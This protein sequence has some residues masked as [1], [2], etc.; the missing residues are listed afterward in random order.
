MLFAHWDSRP[1]SDR[2][3]DP[4]NYHTPIDGANDGAGAC[5]TLLEI[6]RQIGQQQPAVGI[7]ILFFDAEDW[8]VP[9]FDEKNQHISSWC[10]GSDFWARNPHKQNYTARY[11]ILLDMVSAPNARF[12]KEGYSLQS[13]PD[14]VRKVWEAAQ[15]LGYGSYFVAANGSTIEDDH[16]H[17]IRH[18]RI[19][20]IDIIQYDPETESGFGAYW[21]TQDDDMDHVSKKRLQATGQTVMYVIY[22]EKN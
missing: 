10:L 19:P 5:A 6:A 8:G 17:V 12:M 3:P 1:F 13:A 22:H 7:D 9:D 16:V 4:A 2:D 20:C 21:H 15:I 14:I 18:R 11:G